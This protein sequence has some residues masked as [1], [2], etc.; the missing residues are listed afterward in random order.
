MQ[1][2]ELNKYKSK[3]EFIFRRGNKLSA[4]CKEIPHAA[5]VYI[6]RTIKDGTETLVYIGASGTVKQNGTFLKQLM[7]KRLQNMQS[8]KITRQTFFINELDKNKLDGIRV[9]WY[10]TFNEEHQDLPMSVE[11]TLLQKY[12]DKHKQLPIWN[13]EF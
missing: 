7:K 8:K 10:V 13:K 3:G 1:F 11:G 12:F 2:E 4:F 9:N 5:G 6:F